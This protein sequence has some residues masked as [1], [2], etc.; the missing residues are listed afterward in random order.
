MTRAVQFF[1]MVSK[2]YPWEVSL[3]TFLLLI[4]PFLLSAQKQAVQ[5]RLQTKDGKDVAYANVVIKN[6]DNRVVNFKISDAQGNFMIALPDTANNNHLVLEIRHLGYK[7]VRLSLNGQD[8]YKII[9]EEQTIDLSQVE[10]KSKPSIR[11]RGDTLSYQVSNFAK[12]EDRSIGEVLKRLPG[13]EVADNGEIKYNGKSISSLYIDGDDLLAD[14][15]VI[16]SKTIPHGMVKNVEVMQNHQPI[17][18]LQNKVSSDQ[19]ALNLV[20]KEDVKLKM[21]GQ[22]KLG[23]GLPPQYDSEING[24]L[25]NKKYKM[26]NVMKG[27]NI[28]EDLS[29][30]FTA[31]NRSVILSTIGNERPDA[32]LSTGTVGT[33]NLPKSRYYLNES[34]AVNANNLLN[35]RNG[36]QLKSTINILVDR[37]QL[38][39]NGLS[40]T[41]LGEDTIHYSERQALFRHPFL[42]DFTLSAEANKKSHYFKNELRFSYS[43]D[44]A[45]A[46]MFNNGAALNLRLTSKVRD[47]SN[48]LEYIPELHN[49]N[50]I[51]LT[52]YVNYSNLPQQ[53]FLQPGVNA[54]ILNDSV[55]YQSTTQSVQTPTWFNR[56]SLSYGLVKNKVKQ[57]YRL[58]VL[59]ELQH[60]ESVLRLNQDDG[61]TLAFAGSKDNDLQWS[62]HRLYAEANYEYK[63]RR[64]ETSLALPLAGQRIGYKDPY[65]MLVRNQY[66]LLFN[67]A[68][69]LKWMVNQEDYLSTNYTYSNHMGNIGGIYRGAILTN[70]RTI[71]VNNAGL[72]E[73][74]SHNVGLQYNFQRSIAMLFMNAGLNWNKSIANTIASNVVNQNISQTV[75]LPLEN[76][77]STLNTHIEISKFIF[78][79]GSA[80]KIR[81]S[82]STTRY[83]QI[84]N[85]E[86]FP[87][88]NR[89]FS[90]SPNFEARLWSWVS[91]NYRATRTWL[92]SKVITN[93]ITSV[94]PEQYMQ[95]DDQHVQFVFYI[96]KNLFVNIAGRY[97][98]IKQNNRLTYF[99]MDANFRLKLVKLKSDLELNLTNLANVRGYESYHINA[100]N[101]WYSRYDLR[102]RM[103][104]FKYSFNF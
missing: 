6:R 87:Y 100:N 16:G 73:R 32:L 22:A 102:G 78:A 24:I 76:N 27:N 65:F 46:N 59:N 48:R 43:G 45:D 52:W 82:W 35:L 103:A 19:V 39:Y 13:I 84:I 98:S 12:G 33:P 93:G 86:L 57:H 61:R 31:F 60:L 104:V 83:N 74:S 101:I 99:F 26:L 51:Q 5:G 80:A 36:L 92:S 91:F 18:I 25:F 34:V 14:R 56:L 20:I 11:R 47:L 63:A 55:A 69:R 75:L 53:L 15:Y 90:L 49:R 29:L 23:L 41:Y 68:L 8:F 3:T 2:I 30:D 88:N 42:A 94:L 62:R 38:N 28:G 44:R 97:Q 17:K 95:Y 1:F 64:W 21:T 50:V 71:Q 67:P 7:Q 9:L 10:V 89:T 96:G 72:Q 77:V 66:Q 37:N 70:Y 40:D 79:L 81:A 85:N 54:P 4:F 58:G